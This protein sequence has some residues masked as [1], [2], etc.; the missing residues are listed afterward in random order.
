MLSLNKKGFTLVEVLMVIGIAAVIFVFST[1]YSIKFYRANMLDDAQSNVID[2]LGRARHYAVL[3]KNDSNFGVHIS[4]ASSSYTLFQTPDMTYDN[5][6]QANDEVFPVN[7]NLVFS[8]TTDIIF[9]KLTG[10]VSTTSTTTIS[11]ENLTRGILVEES[12]NIFK[13]VSGGGV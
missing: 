10:L 6:V 9:Y 5:R 7:S 4:V 2:A 12:G 8:T 1:P 11:Y 13:A 3:Q